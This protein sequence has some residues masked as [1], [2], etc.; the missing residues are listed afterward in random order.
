MIRPTHMMMNPAQ[1]SLG[2]LSRRFRPYIIVRV[3]KP[4]M[5]KVVKTSALST[6]CSVKP[7]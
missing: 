1:F 4:V 2:T 6:P 5:K 3:K 7:W